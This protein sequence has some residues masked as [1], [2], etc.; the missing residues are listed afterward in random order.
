MG[1]LSHKTGG[2]MY[3]CELCNRLIES[4][5]TRLIPGYVISLEKAFFPARICKAHSLVELHA[6]LHPMEFF[7]ALLESGF[8]HNPFE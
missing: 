1:G 5:N 3:T 2:I 7:R 4:K 8:T 6:R